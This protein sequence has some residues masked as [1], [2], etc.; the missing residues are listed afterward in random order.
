MFKRKGHLLIIYSAFVK[1]PRNTGVKFGVYQL[2]R[3]F[4]RAYDSVRRAVLQNTVGSLV[5][6][7]ELVGLIKM[8][9]KE[10]TVHFG[11][12]NMS[13]TFPTENGLT[14]A[15]VYLHLCS[16]LLYSMSLGGF[17]Q[18]RRA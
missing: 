2:F 12:A 11:K 5:I 8:C 14:K 1:Y 17:S 9:L 13:D 7:T 10:P 4:K 18:T 3:V 6:A 15:N 16:T